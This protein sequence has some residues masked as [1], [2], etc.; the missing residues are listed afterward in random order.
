MD[1]C[2]EDT[3]K[4][5][6]PKLRG[7]VD[8]GIITL[9]DVTDWLRTIY[10]I[11]F[12]E[13]KVFELLGQNIIKGASHLYAG[14]EAVATGAVAAI[15]KSDVIGSTHHGHGHYGA[16]G[17]AD[18][19]TRQEHWNHMMAEL[20]G[21]QTGYCKGRGGSMH[22]AEAGEQKKLDSASIIG[23][24]QPSTVG[25]AVT[26]KHRKTGK[27]IL[28]F[29]GDDST[30]AEAF[31]GSMN[32][33]SALKVP[34]VAIIENNQSGVNVLSPGN[35][36]NRRVNA[37]IIDIAEC[38]HTYNIPAMIV[39]GQ[40]VVAVYLAV[41]SAVEMARQDTQMSVIEMK[42]YRFYA[43]PRAY[44]TK[45]E[46][47]AWHEVDP[48]TILSKKMLSE[49]LCIQETLDCIKNK[50]FNTIRNAAEFGIS[51]SCPIRTVLT[52]NIC[53]QGN[54]ATDSIGD[55]KAVLTAIKQ[56]DKA[57]GKTIVTKNENSEKSIKTT[58]KRNEYPAFRE[59]D[60]SC[61][62]IT[63][64]TTTRVYKL[65]LSTRLANLFGK[66]RHSF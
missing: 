19:N 23:G 9:E 33:A 48:I 26:E 12:F 8:D 65:Q 20:M 6:I 39:D 21:K 47:T 10:E 28:S 43:H 13:E 7:L 22:I 29:F 53:F 38:A 31:Y 42:T 11:R 15:E 59:D 34:L 64:K 44:L 55:E 46:E 52:K 4:K 14:E 60:Y 61:K 63:E 25:T 57:S 30:S 17:N 62:L 66:L 49:K 37:G 40:D 51:R 5:P 2:V 50:A 18:D 3:R 58:L 54:Y 27:V 36:I 24:V 16:I 41:R 56:S 45:V 1:F 35:P 32:M